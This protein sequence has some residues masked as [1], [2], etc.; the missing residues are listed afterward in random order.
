MVWRGIVSAQLT[1][2]RAG[3]YHSFGQLKHPAAAQFD[4]RPVGKAHL[5]FVGSLALSLRSAS[6]SLFSLSLSFLLLLL[7]MVDGLVREVA[8]G[9]KRGGI[10][11]HRIKLLVK[12]NKQ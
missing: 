1:T 2:F 9:S 6:L 10:E 8:A 3:W 4:D 11:I 12:S 5:L 7:E